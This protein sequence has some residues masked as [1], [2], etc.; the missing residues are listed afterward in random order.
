[1]SGSRPIAATTLAD[2]V[3]NALGSWSSPTLRITKADCRVWPLL[4]IE[5]Y[6]T[7]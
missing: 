4:I 2:H 5:Y 1:V 3:V 6:L 7:S